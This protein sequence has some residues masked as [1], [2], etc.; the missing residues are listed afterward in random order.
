MYCISEDCVVLPEPRT[1]SFFTKQIKFNRQNYL[2][3]S[4][5]SCIKNSCLLALLTISSTKSL[6]FIQF[7]LP[8]GKWGKLSNNMRKLA[9]GSVSYKNVY[10]NTISRQKTEM[11]LTESYR[12]VFFC[13][14]V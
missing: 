2:N 9:L 13:S 4:I 8:K 6:I 11:K 12:S 1:S 10:L 14:M 3:R 5:L 7:P